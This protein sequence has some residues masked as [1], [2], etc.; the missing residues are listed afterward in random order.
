LAA[1]DTSKAASDMTN[2]S[3]Q[4][5]SGN[6]TAANQLETAAAGLETAAAALKKEASTTPTPTVPVHSVPKHAEGGVA[7]SPQFGEF[8]EAGPEALLP[9][10]NPSTMAEIAQAIV[11]AGGAGGGLAAGHQTIYQIDTLT[12]VAQ[13]PAQMEQQLA[14]KARVSALS[15]RPSG[16]S[17]LAVAT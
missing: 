5:L 8:G 12:I 7:T 13:N 9:L 16:S 10:S 17:N 4:L 3:K 11:Q 6:T 15:S 14:Q 1:Q 2:A